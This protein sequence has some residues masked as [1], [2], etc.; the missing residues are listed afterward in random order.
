[1][2]LSL[3]RRSPHT[4]GHTLK[5]VMVGSQQYLWQSTEKYIRRDGSTTTLYTWR[6]E[7]ADC[8]EAFTVK[9]PPT[10]AKW[11]NRRCPAHHKPGIPVVPRSWSGPRRASVR[12]RI[13]SLVPDDGISTADL[14]RLAVASAPKPRSG[15]RD[16]RRQYAILAIKRMGALGLVNIYDEW[17]RLGDGD[18]T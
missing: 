3:Y 5:D 16:T 14:L 10:Q 8:G 15:V 13:L 2:V 12:D 6:S 17:V 1:M 4:R 11:V 9:G 7:C 18:L